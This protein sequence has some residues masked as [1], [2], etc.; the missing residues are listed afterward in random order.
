M[1][2]NRETQAR[3]PPRPGLGRGWEGSADAPSSV[4][5]CVE[6]GGKLRAASGVNFIQN[7]PFV[8]WRQS[9]EEALTGHQLQRLSWAWSLQWKAICVY[10][11]QECACP[12]RKPPTPDPPW[13]LLNGCLSKGSDGA[14]V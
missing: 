8:D 11:A 3:S 6:S 5:Q 14:T 9:K 2:G 7:V 4:S 10:S 1:C 12:G 13:Q